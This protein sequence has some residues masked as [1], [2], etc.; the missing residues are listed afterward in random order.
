MPV[1]PHAVT[2]TVSEILVVG[3]V[4][5]VPNHPSRSRV[6]CPAL[7]SRMRRRQHRALRTVHDIEDLLHFVRRLAQDEGSRN[8][9]AV[10]LHLASTIHQDNSSFAYHLRC[11][12]PMW[13]SGELA[14]LHIGVA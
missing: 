7:Q 11:Y 14:H 8:I 3:T 1:H 10:A 6:H 13:E 2:H 5:R 4:T 12:R 9:G